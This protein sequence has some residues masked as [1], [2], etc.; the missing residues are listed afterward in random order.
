MNIL[1][2]GDNLDILRRYVEDESIDLIY[3]DPPF[4]SSQNYNVLFEEKNGSKSMA[5]I[6][7][8]E[9]TWHWSQEAES[10]YHD[11]VVRGGKISE[12]IQSFR[13][14]LGENDMMAYLI[15]MTPRLIELHRVLKSTGSIYLHCDSVASHYLKILMDAIFGPTNFRNEIIWRRTGAHGKTRRFAPIHDTIL[16]YTRS[17]YYKWNFIKKPYMKGHVEKHF[18]KDDNGWR[19]K[20]YGNVLTGS[21]TRNGESGKPWK[22]FD[23]TSKG[24][25]WAIPGA[26][27][28]DIGED[29]SGLSQHQKLDKLYELGYI[30]IVDGH[31]WPVYERYITP[32]DGQAISDIWAYQPYTQGTV[33]GTEEGI[34]EDVRWL[35]PKDQERLGY[36]TQKPE[37]LL[38]RI[39]K[40][41][42]D[43]NDIVLDPFCGCGT[44]IAVAQKLN[45]RWIGIDI[46]HLAISLIKHRLADSFGLEEKKDYAVIGEPT[47]LSGAKELAKQDPYQFQWWALGLLKARPVEQK[48][49]ADKG[50]DGR[51]Y[52]FEKPTDNKPKQIIFS[53]KSG[54]VNVGQIRD[55]RGVVE[56][57]KAAIGVFVTLNEPTKPMIKEA[58]TAGFYSPEGLTGEKYPK[59]QI[60]TIE[61]IL[62]GKT[63]SA[64]PF[65][66]HRDGN[67]T[68]KRAPKIKK[69]K[70]TKGTQIKLG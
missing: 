70:K 42:S 43:E 7:A 20:Y 26:L 15:M 40:A 66:R 22:G 36:P 4:K 9:D 18:I 25:H 69:K 37:G 52:F 6:K 65:L 53:V 34:D 33:F 2:Y 19:T 51:L 45:R 57:E 62:G 55:L 10:S 63:F 29:M 1:Y 54:H 27:L 68:F 14:F 64:P 24:R 17:D 35:S 49:G 67:V 13:N 12:V 56:R 5:Q 3:L 38:E 8:F 50:I 47:T 46:T 44:T 21:G 61:E 32:E 30:K 59:I 31:S 23:P 58:A 28:D 16:F 48:K 41:S 60:L 39:I 11:I